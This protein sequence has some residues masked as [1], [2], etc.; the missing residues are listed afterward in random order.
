[1]RNILEKT[2]AFHGFDKFSD[3][4]TIEANE[5]NLGEDERI[6]HTRRINILSHGNYSIFE[7]QVMNDENKEHFRK[8]LNNFIK[9]YQFNNDLF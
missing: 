6:I 2:A 9:K 1:L 7:P 5:Q 8:V 3:C 4:I